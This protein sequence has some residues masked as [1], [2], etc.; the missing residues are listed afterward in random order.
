MEGFKEVPYP[1]SF[2]TFFLADLGGSGIK[3][4]SSFQRVEGFLALSLL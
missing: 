2:G 3:P 4:A 1:S